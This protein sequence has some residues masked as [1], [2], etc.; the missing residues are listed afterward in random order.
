M[1]LEVLEFEADV[2]TELALMSSWVSPYQLMPRNI[3]LGRS[4]GLV[5]ERGLGKHE[6]PGS[7]PS[8]S[9]CKDHG[10]Q[11]EE[12]DQR[13]CRTPVKQMLRNNGPNVPVA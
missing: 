10:W 4:H 6:V 9:C 2:D 8:I 5:V 7:I 1:S 12:L 11:G 3:S 13:P